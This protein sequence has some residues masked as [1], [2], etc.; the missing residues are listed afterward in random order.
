[1]GA[2]LRACVEVAEGMAYLHARGIVHGDLTGSNVL[3]QSKEVGSLSK[4]VLEGCDT[5]ETFSWLLQPQSVGVV[6]TL[7]PAV[8]P[9]CQGQGPESLAS[10]PQS[11]PEPRADSCVW[12]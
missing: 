5:V 1:M 12:A 7:S 3:L 2:M 10:L 11:L 4:G 8:S 9:A 6:S